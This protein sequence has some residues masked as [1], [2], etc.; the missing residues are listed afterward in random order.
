LQEQVARRQRAFPIYLENEEEDELLHL[1]NIG[2]R[3]RESAAPH[4]VSV[5]SWTG[6]K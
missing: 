1:L 4:I 5:C 3:G 2:R 6:E